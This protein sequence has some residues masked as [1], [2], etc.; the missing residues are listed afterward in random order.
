VTFDEFLDAELSGLRRYAA[1]LTGDRQRA[2]DV[3][4]DALLRAHTG[5]GRIGAMEFPAAYVR[6]IVTSTFLSERRRWSVRHIRT[7]RS[8]ELPDVA[9]PDPASAVDDREH[10]QRLLAGLPPRQRAAVVLRFYL[11]LSYAEVA[12]E[13]GITEGAVRTATSRALAA[14]RISVI[15]EEASTD[16]ALASDSVTTLRPRTGEG[17]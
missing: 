4:A 3:L 6:R 8:G 11:G 5:W 10:L 17:S 9:L 12:A 14:L 1:A 16:R 15:D 7:T 2:H 13:L